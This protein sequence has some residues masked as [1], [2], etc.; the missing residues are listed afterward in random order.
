VAIVAIPDPS[1]VVLIGAAGAGKSTF[2][3]QHF[4]ASEILSSDAFRAMVSG[5]EA[6]QTA[7]RAAFGRLHRALDRRLAAG[8]L[9]VVDATNVE[10]TARR[11]LLKRSTAAGLPAVAIVL[12]LPPAIVLAQ[13]AARTGR[14]VDE[15]VVLRHLAQ[16]RRTLEGSTA[17]FRA[18][19]F[20]RV[21]FLRHP[22][23]VEAARI[24]RQPR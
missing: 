14:I 9:T 7:T 24:V 6:D 21:T 15:P 4:D 22:P 16:L 17:A 5:D 11:E 12:D 8:R 1:L 20:S 18:E 2:A 23:E 10:H 19:G 13:N 3:A